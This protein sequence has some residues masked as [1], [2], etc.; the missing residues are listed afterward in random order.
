MVYVDCV[1][2]WDSNTTAKDCH[3]RDSLVCCL[4]SLSVCLLSGFILLLVVWFGF[5]SILAILSNH[6]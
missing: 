1:A 3:V 2:L 6:M 4:G 5:G